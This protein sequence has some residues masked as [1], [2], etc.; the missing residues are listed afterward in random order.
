MFSPDGLGSNQPRWNRSPTVSLIL[1]LSRSFIVKKSFEIV[2]L[3]RLLKG[4]TSPL[5]DRNRQKS[6]SVARRCISHSRIS[7][8]SSV[9]GKSIFSV[10]TYYRPE[11]APGMAMWLERII[12]YDHLNYPWPVVLNYII[13]YFGAHQ[14]SP[15]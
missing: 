8:H 2:M 13:D 7:P 5:T 15:P 1:I 10:R 11:L 3:R 14:N 6:L 4:Y 9:L 12:Y